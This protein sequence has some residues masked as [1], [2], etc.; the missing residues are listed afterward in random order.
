MKFGRCS[1]M[2][3][4]VVWGSACGTSNG[5]MPAIDG[6]GATA[7]TVETWAT[8]P[9]ELSADAIPNPEQAL[10]SEPSSSPDVAVAG[11]SST[12]V[13]AA[14][15]V[16]MKRRVDC[17]RRPRV[18]DVDALAVVGSPLHGRLTSLIAERRSAGIAASTRGSIRYRLEDVELVSAERARITT[19]LTD[20]TVLI[21]AGAVFDDG[22]FSAETIWTME[23]VDGEWLWVD[24]AVVHWQRGEDLCGFGS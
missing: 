8:P 13:G 19:C 4:A 6:P 5:A 18:C 20:D 12:D 24:D 17:G 2:V 14:F 16:L 10:P 9:S 7:F 11:T 21:S 22:L 1:A 23:R 15:A 3:M